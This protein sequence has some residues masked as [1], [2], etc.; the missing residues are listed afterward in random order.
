[1]KIIISYCTYVEAKSLRG[2]CKYFHDYTRNLRFT[3]DLHPLR[4]RVGDKSIILFLKYARTLNNDIENLKF[5][6]NK[7]GKFC[8]M[9]GNIICPKYLSMKPCLGGIKGSC[10][11]NNT[12]NPIYID[13][14]QYKNSGLFMEFKCIL[15]SASE[16]FYSKFVWMYELYIQKL[17]FVYSFDEFMYQRI[18]P[19]SKNNE[20]RRVVEKHTTR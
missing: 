3:W 7:L 5:I 11:T 6:Q 8:D 9:Y 17:F 15:L 18:D 16:L 10:A 19:M 4:R 14:F 12:H 2:C 13:Y 1:M 20:V